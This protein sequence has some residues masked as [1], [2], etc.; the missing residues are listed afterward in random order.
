MMKSTLFYDEMLIFPNEFLEEFNAIPFNCKELNRETLLNENC[1][2]LLSRSTIKV[3][4]SLLSGVPIQYYATATAGFDHVDM[5][6]VK[7]YVKNHFIASGSNSNSVAEY[8][9]INLE[10]YRNRLNLT[11]SDLTIGII[12]FGHI[13]KKV[14]FYCNL[15]GIKILVNDPPLKDSGFVFP[16]YVEYVELNDL[17]TRANIVTN[18][19]P[20]EKAGMYATANLLSENIGLIQANSLFIHASRGGVVDEQALI[21]YSAENKLHLAV[22]VWV[23]EPFAANELIKKSDIA[24]PHVAGHSINAKLNASQ[25]IINDLF[26]KGLAKK[27]YIIDNRK[28][29]YTTASNIAEK[30]I[31]AHSRRKIVEDSIQFKHNPEIFSEFR[32]NYPQRK[33]SLFTN[34]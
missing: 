19:V 26:L 28:E 14:A 34:V 3:N 9:L 15:L 21:K 33:E 1:N 30:L 16:D 11:Y 31:L 24:T 6:F 7:K 5:P 8:V 17:L 22:D 18:H 4:E 23:K 20:L 32:K 2:I 25:M 13:G 29:E 12:G 27:T 10:I